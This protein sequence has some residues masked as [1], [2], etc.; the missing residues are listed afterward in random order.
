M[1]SISDSSGEIL[2]KEGLENTNT[3]SDIISSIWTDY[4]EIGDQI[5]KK[6]KLSYLTL[7]NEDSIVIATDLFGYV[8]AVKTQNNANIGFV[9]VHLE[10]VVKSLTAKF[11][12]FREIIEE[13]TKGTES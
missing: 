12:N 13:R 2:A 9:K 6:E 5:F 1:V 3:I 10:A 11:K 4:N 7:E 8:V